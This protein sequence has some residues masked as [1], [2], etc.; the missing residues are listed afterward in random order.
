MGILDWFK[1]DSTGNASANFQAKSAAKSSKEIELPFKDA[2]EGSH[3]SDYENKALN[4]EINIAYV[5]IEKQSSRR[6]VTAKMFWHIPEENQY[7]IQGYCHARNGNRTFR[8]G[9]INELVLI[10]T[11]EVIPS[12]NY[13]S[14][15]ESEH[16]K[17]P[18]YAVSQILLK[19]QNEINLA[20]FIAE[21]DGRFTAKEKEVIY[22]FIGASDGIE[23]SEEIIAKLSKE[24]KFI[25]A[26]QT[27][28]KKSA[29]LI[30]ESGE[31]DIN[32]IIDML[33]KIVGTT[34]KVNPV[35]EA[36]YKLIRDILQ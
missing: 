5:D 15:F 32:A 21:S 29:K 33:E 9:R 8:V 27:K 4:V 24:L 35:T 6:D 19:Y 28:A 22:E 25:N 14:F 13:L 7:F 3:Y 31:S 11:G 12:E 30:K 17:S 23:L 36:S 26:K 18:D 16:K 1:K 20:I 2:W 34:K 10:E